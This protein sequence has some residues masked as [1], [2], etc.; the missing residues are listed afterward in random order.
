M[1][2]DTIPEFSRKPSKCLQVAVS[3]PDSAGIQGKLSRRSSL[4][5]DW[6]TIYEIIS[7]RACDS[8]DKV[9]RLC[10]FSATASTSEK[11]L[12]RYSANCSQTKIGTASP[13]T[14]DS[15]SESEESHPGCQPC[16]DSPARWLIDFCRYVSV[17]CML[18]SR[19]GTRRLDESRVGVI[20]GPRVECGEAIGL[21]PAKCWSGLGTV[22]AMRRAQQEVCGHC[23]DIIVMLLGVD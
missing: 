21:R 5:S 14:S 8:V 6:V 17:A 7:W 12:R 2:I 22:I 19:F 11:R 15:E 1:V 13:I 20:T 4:L 9:H 10:V 16:S 18:T 23:H 3:P